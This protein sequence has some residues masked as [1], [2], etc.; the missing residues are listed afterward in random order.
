M[1]KTK[2]KNRRRDIKTKRLAGYAPQ[3]VARQLAAMEEGLSRNRTA[4]RLRIVIN[5]LIRIQREI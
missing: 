2:K 5:N 3:K 1:P 4:I